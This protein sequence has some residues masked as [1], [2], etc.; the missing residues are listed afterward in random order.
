MPTSGR[1]T[2]AA[3]LKMTQGSADPARKPFQNVAM[4]WGTGGSSWP[5]AREL[6]WPFQRPDSAASAAASITDNTTTAMPQ[7]RALLAG[8]PGGGVASRVGLAATVRR[9]NVR[10][11]VPFGNST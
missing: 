6:L 9:W 11:Y 10:A 7:L 8:C 4:G 3:L 2:K 1:P 5:A